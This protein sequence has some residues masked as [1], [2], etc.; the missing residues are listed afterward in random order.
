[1]QFGIIVK[2]PIKISLTLASKEKGNAIQTL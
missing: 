1:M 2:H